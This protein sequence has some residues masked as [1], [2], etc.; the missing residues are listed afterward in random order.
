L[1]EYEDVSFVNP[2]YVLKRREI[3][4]SYE[5]L[6]YLVYGYVKSK[7]DVITIYKG[8]KKYC[9]SELRECRSE[10]LNCECEAQTINHLSNVDVPCAAEGRYIMSKQHNGR[11]SQDLEGTHCSAHGTTCLGSEIE[12]QSLDE[13]FTSTL[14]SDN[15][16]S[17]LN[18]SLFSSEVDQLKCNHT[19]NLV[20]C[21]HHS[22]LNGVQTRVVSFNCDGKFYILKMENRLL[23]L[24]SVYQFE[25]VCLSVDLK[26][27]MKRESI[28]IQQLQNRS[29]A[30]SCWSVEPIFLG[31]WIISTGSDPPLGWP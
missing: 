13:E 29:P 23:G 22:S 19:G 7:K 4:Y 30:S 12:R 17:H 16:V 2:E 9:F 14:S 8:E 6:I 24:E 27:L 25:Y 28:K 10:V 1:K 18:Q 15:S 26:Q 21:L 5:D 20:E 11:Q 3:R 31:R